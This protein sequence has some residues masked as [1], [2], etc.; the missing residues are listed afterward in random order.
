[1]GGDVI[2]DVDGKPTAGLTL[3]ELVDRLRGPVGTLVRLELLRNGDTTPIE[4]SLT[5]EIVTVHSVAYRVEDDNVGYIKIS[6]FDANTTA[7]LKTAI[8]ELSRRIPRDRLKGYILDLRNDPGG[9][10][11]QA[12]A[13]ADTFLTHGD[14]VSLRGRH[15]EQQRFD[16]GPGDLLDGSHLI[17]LIN[18]GSA[19]AAEIV[20]AAL[21]DDKRATIV[22]SQSF[23][24]GSV[25]SI[26]PLGRGLG[27]LRLTTARYYTPSGRSLQAQGV[28]PDVV[29]AQA[30]P[31]DVKTPEHPFS[32]AGL[33]GH[34]KSS[35][36]EK[37]GSQTYIPPEAKDDR[38]LQAALGLLRGT[39]S[40][41][42]IPT[43]Q[44]QAKQ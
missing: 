13:V 36:P 27:A 23:G 18:G 5:R 12:V 38:A 34:L 33:P 35:G 9:L 14:I 15:G 29:V 44:T 42:A 22:G 40:N 24:K 1:M 2:A 43:P 26:I 25:Q 39:G 37:L 21:Q 4:L 16:A 31:P 30:I 17:V 3:T 6:E 32:E 8:A 10:L 28:T 41:A 11:S 7:E 19:S 20:A